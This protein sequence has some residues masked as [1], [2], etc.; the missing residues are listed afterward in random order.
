MCVVYLDLANVSTTESGY[1][2]PGLIKVLCL[3]DLVIDALDDDQVG[4]RLGLAAEILG[5]GPD[6]VQDFL[7]AVALPDLFAEFLL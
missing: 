1:D 7:F 4:Q 2:I 6:Q 3:S 5:Q